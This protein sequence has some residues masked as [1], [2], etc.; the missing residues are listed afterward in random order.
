MTRKTSTLRVPLNFIPVFQNPLGIFSAGFVGLW[1][2]MAKIQSKNA[3]Y[4]TLAFFISYS[5]TPAEWEPAFLRQ[6]REFLF[7]PLLPREASK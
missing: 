2:K 4:G 1:Y 5:T 7:F 3:S 6:A